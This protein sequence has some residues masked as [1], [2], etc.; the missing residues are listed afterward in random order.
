MKIPPTQEKSGE[1]CVRDK[2]SSDFPFQIICLL[3]A[4]M[5]TSTQA[6]STGKSTTEQIGHVKRPRRIR[7]LDF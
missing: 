7:L 1:A 3:S 4:L 2:M 5:M 6:T